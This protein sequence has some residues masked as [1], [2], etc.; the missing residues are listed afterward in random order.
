MNKYG[1][2]FLFS[3]KRCLKRPL[4]VML[5]LLLP[6]T[7]M[8]LN[9]MQEGSSDKIAVALYTEEDS[10]NMM[11]AEE[12]M[13]DGSS[14]RFY[15][16]GTSQELKE[17]VMAGAA[18]CGY[19]LPAG[20]KEKLDSNRYKRAITVVTAPSTVTDKLASEVFFGGLFRVYARNLLQE[21]SRTSQIFASMDR[22]AVWRDLEPLFDQYL[23]NGSTFS[24][25]YETAEGKAVEDNTVKAEFPAKGI[26]AIFI[27]VMGMAAAAGAGEDEKNGVFTAICRGRKNLI[28]AVQ[29]GALVF[30]ACLS[31]LAGLAAAGSMGSILKEAV[32]LAL[33]GLVVTAYAFV[34]G[35]ILKN[36]L[37][38]S[39]FIP[40]LIIICLTAC[41]VFADLS[42]F[43]PVLKV[44]R[45]FL[46]PY[47]YLL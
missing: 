45:V 43:V 25:Q 23:E 14:F 22:E 9:R 32:S 4:F 39:G 26:T 40:F 3:C 35:R 47:Y 42:V 17:D 6:L 16:C 1:L 34:F 36:P 24:F 11:V 7:L 5:L 12:L 44:I 33:Y 20:L 38:I 29:I 21:F 2:W 31:G 15:L 28:M 37:L 10:W 19:L 30:L 41:P 27:L 46:P 8:G 18:E 13:K